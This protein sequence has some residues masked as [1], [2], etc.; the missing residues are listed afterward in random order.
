MTAAGT[1]PLR[2]LLI[3]ARFQ[4]RGRSAYTLRLL[5]HLEA[6]GISPSAVT[7]S[8]GP[9]DQATRA[10]LRIAE[11]AGL[12][13]PLWS[14]VVRYGASQDLGFVPPQLLHIQSRRM[15]SVGNWLAARW[16]IPYILTVH[17]Q[18]RAR[19]R[20]RLDPE[21]CR[22]VI[23]TSEEAADS[24]MEHSALSRDFVRTIP[25][26]VEIPPPTECPPPLSG[27]KL[28]VVGTGGP[29]EETKGFPYL[30]GAA[31]R[32]L[33][34]GAGAEFLIAGAGPEESNLRRLARE[35]GISQRV[36]FAPFVA[37]FSFSLS[38]MDIFVFP[39]LQNGLGTVLLEAMAARRAVIASETPAT[40]AVIQE[41][42]NGLLVPRAESALLAMRIL[43]LLRNPAGAQRMG[44]AARETIR[45]RFGV[46]QMVQRTAELYHAVLGA[47]SLPVPAPRTG[48]VP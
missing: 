35:L 10:A 9:L 43:E 38:A 14:R 24:V 26:G 12:D 34:A 45:E 13:H 42:E 32:V 36:T 4:A 46:E 17:D 29:L 7:P 5:R 23:A 11:Y 19:D 37:D 15:L 8:A 2:V 47:R 33:A 16:R 44:E 30:I 40:S 1:L 48:S 22:G 3:A 41:G 31:Q 25:I 39:S 27:E 18:I 21:F 6:W 28:P 20:L